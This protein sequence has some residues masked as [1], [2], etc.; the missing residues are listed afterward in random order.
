MD[1]GGGPSPTAN[2]E[3]ATPVHS[4]LFTFPEFLLTNSQELL[5]HQT[6]EVTSASGF[7]EFQTK[8]ICNNSGHS[9]APGV[10]I[11][12][13]AHAIHISSIQHGTS[14]RKGRQLK[15][16]VAIKLRRKITDLLDL[17]TYASEG[18]ESGASTGTSE[19]GA[20]A[21]AYSTPAEKGGHALIIESRRQQ[22]ESS[23]EVICNLLL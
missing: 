19:G 5:G 4:V 18:G 14:L 13:L 17:Q 20:L 21:E 1:F 3:R 16:L 6:S 10:A 12:L 8:V 23:E 7:A 9:L 15:N 22:E 2:G 11:V